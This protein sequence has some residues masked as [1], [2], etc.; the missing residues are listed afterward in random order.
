MPI[1]LSVY[2]GAAI[3]VTPDHRESAINVCCGDSVPGESVYPVYGGDTESGDTYFLPNY[4]DQ[5]IRPVRWTRNSEA[6]VVLDIDK[7]R[8]IAV[9]AEGTKEFREAL[10]VPYEIV[11]GV[12]PYYY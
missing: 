4:D 6:P 11:W 10:T 9:F 5:T 2:V 3:K 12:I 8:D 1:H 7:E